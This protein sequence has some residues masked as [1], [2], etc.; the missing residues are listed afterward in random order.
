MINEICPVCLLG[1]LINKKKQRNI[2][3]LGVH[4]TTMFYYSQCN[5]CDTETVSGWQLTVNKDNTLTFHRS[6]DGKID[7]R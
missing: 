2:T 1:E 5:T 6:V 3:Y 7:T 4:G